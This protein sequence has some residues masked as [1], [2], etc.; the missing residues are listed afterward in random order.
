MP[1]LLSIFASLC[2]GCLGLS[3]NADGEQTRGRGS[4]LGQQVN[5]HLLGVDRNTLDLAQLGPGD[6]LGDHLQS[7]DAP[8]AHR[9][10]AA[11]TGQIQQAV[12]VGIADI[13]VGCTANLAN[14]EH[15]G[16]GHDQRDRA[17]RGCSHGNCGHRRL[18]QVAAAQGQRHGNRCRHRNRRQ[19]RRWAASSQLQALDGAIGQ[20]EEEQVVGKGGHTDQL[21]GCLERGRRGIGFERIIGVDGHID[22]LDRLGRAGSSGGWSQD[23]IEI[24][25]LGGQQDGRVLRAR[26]DGRRGAQLGLVRQEQAQLI[27]GAAAPVEQDRQPRLIGGDI[28]HLGVARQREGGGQ[29]ARVGQL[30]ELV[31]VLVEP[32]GVEPAWAGARL[33]RGESHGVGI[34]AA[35]VD[36][37]HRGHAGTQGGDG[38]LVVVGLDGL[39]GDAGQLPTQQVGG[40]VT[41][42]AAL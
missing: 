40:L 29:A 35:L 39:P 12:L 22:D 2:A 15:V 24:V 32:E 4:V 41:Q 19:G 28:E 10:P 31:E 16:M 38:R 18:A 36:R 27:A 11:A 23:H 13:E 26:L 8:V 17:C 30:F 33:H 5:L 21:F 34:G 20:Q 42:L 9:A 1:R 25:A 37:S 14:G 7:L 3:I 6:I